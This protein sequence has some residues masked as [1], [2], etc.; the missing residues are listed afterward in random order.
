M[1][2][3]NSDHIPTYHGLDLIRLESDRDTDAARLGDEDGLRPADG[4]GLFTI[5]L[6]FVR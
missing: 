6:P 2:I 4:R 5:C 1:Y 3:S